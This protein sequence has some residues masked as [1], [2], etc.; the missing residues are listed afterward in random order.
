M[1][2]C[3]RKVRRGVRKYKMPTTLIDKNNIRQFQN[4]SK[5]EFSRHEKRYH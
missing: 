2:G 3:Q 1:P 4:K 5:N